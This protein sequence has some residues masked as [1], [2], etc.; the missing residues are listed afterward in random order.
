MTEFSSYAGK[1]RSATS[2]PSD[3]ATGEFYYNSLWPNYRAEIAAWKSGLDSPK[4]RAKKKGLFERLV[5]K[6]KNLVYER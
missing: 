5:S 1:I 4:P 3:Q 2:D 6:I